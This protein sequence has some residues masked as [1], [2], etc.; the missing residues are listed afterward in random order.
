MD[1]HRVSR[2]DDLAEQAL[3]NSLPFFKRELGQILTQQL[4]KSLGIVH[5]V[6]PMDALLSRVGSLPAFL[7][8]LAQLRREFL[9]PCLQLM[10]V[11]NLGLIGIE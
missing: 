2:H 7:G 8:N 1:V 9:P 5:D 4:T 6:L 10:Q 3:G 11:E